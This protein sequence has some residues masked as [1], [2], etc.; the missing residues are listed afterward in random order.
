MHT[1]PLLLLQ[2][3]IPYRPLLSGSCTSGSCTCL[4]E[5]F[6]HARVVLARLHEWFFP[7]HASSRLPTVPTQAGLSSPLKQ[8]RLDVEILNRVIDVMP[9][10]YCTHCTY[11]GHDRAFVVR[12]SCDCFLGLTVRL[13]CKLLPLGASSFLLQALSC[14]KLVPLEGGGYI[15]TYMS[16]PCLWW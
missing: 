12:L 10:T 6:L 3:C 13:S 16:S 11:I 7:C 4:H 8:V 2:A 14:C 1:T 15:H 5:C 9:H